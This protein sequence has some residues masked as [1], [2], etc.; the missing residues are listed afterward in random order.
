[1]EDWNIGT[2]AKI[3]TYYSII[4]PFHY[5]KMNHSDLKTYLIHLSESG[6]ER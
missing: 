5:S 6:V 1:M 3:L 2:R 4:P